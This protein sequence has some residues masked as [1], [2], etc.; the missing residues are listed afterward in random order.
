[1]MTMQMLENWWLP[2]VNILLQSSAILGAGSL[3]AFALRRRAAVQRVLVLRAALCATVLSAVLCVALLGRV[4]PLWNLHQPAPAVPM[5]STTMETTPAAP[6]IV[7]EETRVVPAAPIPAMAPK[8]AVPPKIAAPTSE[9]PPPLRLKY[10]GA[11][12]WL[13]VTGALLLWTLACHFHLWRLRRNA[14]VVADENATRLLHQLASEMKISAPRLLESAQVCGPLLCGLWRPVLLWPSQRPFDCDDAARRAIFVHELTHLQRRD[15]WW[16][17]LSRVLCAFLWPQ[18]LA[19]LVARQLEADSEECCDAAVIAAGCER[20]EYAACLL[21]WAERLSLPRAERVA[22]AGVIPLR[23]S[24]GRRVRAIL[25]E[26]RRGSLRL[27]RRARAVAALV[28]CGGVG[29]SLLI[30]ATEVPVAKQNSPETTVRAFVQALNEK[31]AKALA[32]LVEGAMPAKDL[33]RVLDMIFDQA[34]VSDAQFSIEK[35]SVQG[36]TNIATVIAKT[37]SVWK[38]Q[39][40]TQRESDE[41]PFQLR[42]FDDGWKILA[43]TKRDM[44]PQGLNGWRGFLQIVAPPETEQLQAWAKNRGAATLVGRVVDENGQ[45]VP[46]VK[47]TAQMQSS[48][49]QRFPDLPQPFDL[50]QRVPELPESLAS[51]F[52]Q[53]VQTGADGTYRVSGLTN[54]DYEVFVPSPEANVAEQNETKLPE[55]VSLSRQKVFAEERQQVTVPAIKMTPGAVIEVGV[56]DKVTGKPLPRVSIYHINAKLRDEGQTAPLIQVNKQG[57]LRFRAAP[58]KEYIGFSNW[59]WSKNDKWIVQSGAVRYLLRNVE[60]RVD[61]KRAT[62]Q[63]GNISINVFDGETHQVTFRLQSYIAPV[64]STGSLEPAGSPAATVR[65]FVKALN[66]KDVAQYARY[67]EGAL[68]LEKLN[69]IS[70]KQIGTSKY[71]ITDFQTAINGAD[72]TVMVQG[73]SQW[74]WPGRE[75]QTRTDKSSLR[76]RR[77]NGA[78][79]IVPPANWKSAEAQSDLNW[80]IATLMAPPQLDKLRNWT[81]QNGNA[82]VTGRVVAEKGGGA[83][84]VKLYVAMRNSSMQTIPGSP[85]NVEVLWPWLNVYPQIYA[86]FKREI[87]TSQ[88]GTY[89]I[90]GL[91]N[92]TYDIIVEDDN[93]G[94]VP[95]AEIQ[96]V[97]KPHQVIAAPTQ[98]L[99]RGVVV[100]VRVEDRVTGQPLPDVGVVAGFPG[101]STRYERDTDR[102]GWVRLRMPTGKNKISLS[103]RVTSQ[104]RGQFV[105]KSN[106]K[107][108]SMSQGNQVIFDSQVVYHGRSFSEGRPFERW[109]PQ[110]NVAEGQ[111]NTVTFRLQPYIADSRVQD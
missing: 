59:P 101:L 30:G 16:S 111:P 52:K 58:G 22:G 80:S 6:P 43:P 71:S 104:P 76:L 108:Y 12:L 60:A 18:V 17:A 45:P 37:R 57:I 77:S 73:I 8:I 32:E 51:F 35:L 62:F 82:T 109:P 34:R 48:S 29:L 3:I 78:W 89:R 66:A 33:Q 84:G 42:R 67:V 4:R 28:M 107:L 100:K 53:T 83:A 65:A 14:I 56:L 13:S 7:M 54:A 98:M 91:A 75:K 79:K 36:N 87:V 15:L 20:R 93:I 72:A 55:R 70:A 95:T 41:S 26:S 25:D 86:M 63:N 97:A 11:L 39:G 5:M 21:D 105:L 110:I 74:Q 44:T 64:A 92:G 99:T 47:I 69:V 50:F 96:V 68:P 88:D 49:V 61:G 94:W 103:S 23:S 2:A 102:N 81:Q 1:M 19:W 46:K 31:D 90:I 106:G 40:K 27:S 10:L 38:V 85:S 9:K 24:L